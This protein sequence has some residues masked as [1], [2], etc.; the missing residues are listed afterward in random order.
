MLNAWAR[1]RWHWSP[2]WSQGVQI[3][4]AWRSGVYW[5]LD[6]S[7]YARLPAYGLL[8]AGT[9][10]RWQRGHQHITLRLWGRNLGNVHYF[11]GGGQLSVGYAYA[12]AAGP[13]RSFG[14]TLVYGLD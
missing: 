10:L 9:A 4:Y 7:R 8:N 14:A 13:S 2:R 5:T 11:T 3:S 1:T 12:A 6:D